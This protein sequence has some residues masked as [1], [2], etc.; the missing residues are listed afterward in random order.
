[1]IDDMYKRVFYGFFTI[2]TTMN[3]NKKKWAITTAKREEKKCKR[4]TYTI[5]ERQ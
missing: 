1:M 4:N 3:K 2:S 5:N